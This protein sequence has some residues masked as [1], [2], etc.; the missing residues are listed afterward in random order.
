MPTSA[1]NLTGMP[2]V[3][4]MFA[5]LAISLKRGSDGA[6]DKQPGISFAA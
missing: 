1:G 5:Q 3:E 4:L 2:I 6:G